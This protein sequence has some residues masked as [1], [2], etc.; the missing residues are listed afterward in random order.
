MTFDNQREID[1]K[2]F[3]TQNAFF[4]SG[5]RYHDVSLRTG[6]IPLNSTGFDYN[7]Y[8]YASHFSVLF[9]SPFSSAS[10]SSSTEICSSAPGL[11]S[12]VLFILSGI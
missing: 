8:I 6:G 12:T 2:L 11:S 5:L 10:K 1:E 3:K 4:F 7:K 9:T